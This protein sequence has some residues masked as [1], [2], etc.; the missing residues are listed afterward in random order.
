M[1]GLS[2]YNR[3]LAANQKV[4][5]NV[6]GTTIFLRSATGEIKVRARSTNVGDRSGESYE[7]NMLAAEEWNHA[8]EFDSLEVTDN[9]GADNTIEMY[10]GYGRYR[11]PI[12][13]IVNVST[14]VPASDDINTPAA[15]DPVDAGGGSPTQLVAANANRI[16]ITL[17][18]DKANDQIVRVGDSN[19]STTRG[20][21]LEAGEAVTI[22]STDAIY[23]IEE[24]AGA[25]LINI[26][27]EVV[28]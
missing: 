9:S 11:K 12:P 22:N 19:T 21:Q 18:A 1:P 20:I 17:Q 16:S 23:G 28:V 13:D 27:E 24:A 10:I 2:P 15:V 4:D 6:R 5:I 25:N 14:N 7:L 8:Q 3:T 26:I